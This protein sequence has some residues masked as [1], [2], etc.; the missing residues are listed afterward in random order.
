MFPGV[1]VP[2]G[3]AVRGGP[4]AEAAVSW[5]A[6]RSPAVFLHRDVSWVWFCFSM[7]W[8]RSVTQ[9]SVGFCGCSGQ[10]CELW[11]MG[12]GLKDLLALE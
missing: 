4:G 1:H 3:C 5:L 2:L 9:L 11:G 6:F 12:S 10:L 7:L 8:W